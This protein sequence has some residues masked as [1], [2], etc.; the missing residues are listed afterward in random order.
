MA[1]L[2]T[3][4]LGIRLMATAD[5]QKEVVFNEAAVAFD[6]LVTRT[7]L[8]VQSVPPSTPNAGDTYI[9]G[10]GPSGAWGGYA[11]QIA[12]FYNGWRFIAQRRS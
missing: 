9:I 6:T 12:F 8:S 7:A 1:A 3:P 10:T 5:V 2:T 4:K 11:G